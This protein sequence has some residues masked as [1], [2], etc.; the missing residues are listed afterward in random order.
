MG[1]SL[2]SGDNETCFTVLG[3]AG[4]EL[5]YLVELFLAVKVWDFGSE[6]ERKGVSS[7][8]V[9][10]ICPWEPTAHHSTWNVHIC[11]SN[12]RA[13][14][15]RCLFA[16]FHVIHKFTMCPLS[17]CCLSVCVKHDCF[18]SLRN[19]VEWAC[20]SDET[21]PRSSSA[22]LCACMDAVTR[23]SQ[24]LPLSEFQ[25]LHLLTDPWT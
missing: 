12:K 21:P 18:G 4:P 14:L 9:V 23:P 25:S 20:P 24:C 19:F 1:T 7:V 17:V 5:N 8:H 16:P 13:K 22:A 6:N 10:F 15:E 3:G 11:N 2:A